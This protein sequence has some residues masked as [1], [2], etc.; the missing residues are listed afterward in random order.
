[1]YSFKFLPRIHKKDNSFIW[2]AGLIVLSSYGLI[3]FST[4]T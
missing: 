2:V 1:M 3:I 4:K